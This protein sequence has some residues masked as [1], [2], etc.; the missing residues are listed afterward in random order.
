L[1]LANAL[2]GELETPPAICKSITPA[3]NGTEIEKNLCYVKQSMPAYLAR[4]TCVD[5]GMRLFQPDSSPNARAALTSFGRTYF[6]GSQFAKFYVSGRRGDVCSI[7]RGNGELGENKC[8]YKMNFL[9]EYFELK[10]LLCDSSNPVSCTYKL[11]ITRDNLIMVVQSPATYENVTALDLQFTPGT[12]FLPVDLAAT[13][14]NLEVIYAWKCSVA[15][16]NRRTFAGLTK[17]RYLDLDSNQI[18]EV[19]SSMFEGLTTLGFSNNWV[20]R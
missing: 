7:A 14:P 6:K 17:L 8:F 3:M 16:L 9:C 18:T 13:F 2:Y 15:T 12:T 10:H 19:R 20:F 11:P 5:N 1:A 4:K